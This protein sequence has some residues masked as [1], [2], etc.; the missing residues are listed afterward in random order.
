LAVAAS[1]SGAGVAVVEG[2]VVDDE[3][4]GTVAVL[5]A[6]AAADERTLEVGAVSV[7]CCSGGTGAMSVGAGRDS[8]VRSSLGAGGTSLAAALDAEAIVGATMRCANI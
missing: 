3:F 7:T 8:V 2:G 4:N 5:A 1:A 6:T